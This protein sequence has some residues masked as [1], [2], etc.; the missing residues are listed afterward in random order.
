MDA[1]R[2]D[3]R[4]AIRSITR[5]PMATIVA[6]LSLGAGIGATTV[7][8]TIRNI[9]F[10]N[11]PPLYHEPGQL[12]KIQTARIDRPIG[13]D[14][15]GALYAAWHD[16]LGLP[17]AAA[18]SARG[19]RDVRTADRTDTVPV[20]AA[21]AEFFAVLGVGPEVG[22][23]FGESA[24]GG[25]AQAVLSYRLWQQLFDGRPDVIG[26]EIW[27][28]NRPYT[29]VGVT[30][31]RFWFSEM[32]SPIWTLLDGQ[33]VAAQDALQVVVRRP[34]GMT[35]EMLAARL[36][37][38]LTDYASRLAGAERQRHL[39]VSGIQGTPMGDQMTF[40]LPY[41][42]GTAVLLTLLIACA[43]VAIL[44]I[45][46]WTAR[47]HE[48]A[49]RASLG[50]SRGRIVRALL[51]E[52]VLVAMAGGALG[53]CATLA[54]QG[55]LIH[56]TGGGMFF[57]FS[58][59]PAVFVQSAIVTLAT[60][61]IVGVAPALTE[62]RRLH[63]NPLS[64]IA[65]SDRVQQR[66]RHALV[67]LE[68]TVTVALLVETGAMVDRD[69]G[70]HGAARAVDRDRHAADDDGDL[71]SAGVRDRA[72]IEGTGAAHR[73][74]RQRTG[75]DPAGLGAQPAARRDR[76]GA[77]HRRDVRPDANRA[78]RRRRRQPVRSDVARVRHSRRDRR[79]HRRARDVDSLQASDEDQSGCAVTHNLTSNGFD[80]SSIPRFEIYTVAQLMAARP[81][82]V[83]V[84]ED[85]GDVGR[86]AQR[87][88]VRRDEDVRRPPEDV[89]GRQRLLLKHIE[90]RAP[91]LPA[92]QRAGER[93]LVDDRSASR[94]DEHRAR[95]QRG[96]QAGVDEV[97]RPG[98]V[99]HHADQVVEIRCERDSI[100]AMEVRVD[101]GTRFARARVSL[102]AH[103]EM[104]GRGSQ[105]RANRS[106]AEQADLFP[107][108]RA[109]RLRIPAAGLLRRVLLE[110][111]ALVRE[112]VAEHVLG[113]QRAEDAAR[114]GQ[115][116]I[117]AQRWIEQRF[118]AGPRGL[119]PFHVRQTR[120]RRP[121]E[122]WLAKHELERI[123]GRHFSG[124]G[125][126]RD[127]QI[128]QSAR[129]DQPAIGRGML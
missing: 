30:P 91:Q 53:V 40:I 125:H 106:D 39:K 38:G 76:H 46:Q 78:R 45:A 123:R 114:V 84:D 77:G 15:P 102:H 13:S 11:P 108:Q 81:A 117:A 58:I 94:V 112:H 52:S 120:E 74:R 10:R 105:R 25:D 93:R 51:T 75:S 2:Q 129:V 17:S 95:R 107:A 61:I 20:R 21:T 104:F 122:R 85:G 3:V 87:G 99:R 42:L 109:G 128:R 121:D 126:R 27:V 54:L 37:N 19:V 26:R 41:M 92:L 16:A 24:A 100:G 6:V 116:V 35:H 101:I 36:Q 67:V 68:I 69:A 72:A 47:E 65:G 32:S 63:A 79:G 5:S 34:R 9:I 12:S 88:R 113:H 22:R 70:R 80:T 64:A 66:W 44:M 28:D 90:D 1:L 73:D 57:D 55:I 86:V 110:H 4:G 14:V 97:T 82:A 60:G 103:P 127:V 118:H 7:T 59:D 49:I 98:G 23:L 119:H 56:R 8:L 50:A 33:A 31:A 62:T 48:I 29:V 18:T 43:N 71:R 111:Q 124:I 83:V 96:E 115:D 89:I